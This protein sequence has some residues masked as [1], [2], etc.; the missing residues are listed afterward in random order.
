MLEIPRIAEIAQEVFRKTL[1]SMRVEDVQVEPRTD[2][3]GNDALRVRVIISSSAVEELKHGEAVSTAHFELGQ[4]LE[5]A[6]EDRFPIV[7]YATREE[8]AADGDFDAELAAN[9][10]S[11]P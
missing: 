2:S 4:R 6:G 5:L 10:D 9:G 11:E 1:G 7:E 8:L 3:L